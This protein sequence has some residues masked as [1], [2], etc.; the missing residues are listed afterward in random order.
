M[1]LV[2]QID[3]LKVR[4]VHFSPDN[5]VVACLLQA[6]ILLLHFSSTIETES[7]KFPTGD[8]LRQC[9]FGW[10]SGRI[11][12]LLSQNAL[13][14][15]DRK[16]RKYLNS[17]SL[18]QKSISMAIAA[19][20][21]RIVIGCSEGKLLVYSLKYNILTTIETQVQGVI[22][23]VGFYPFKKHIVAAGGQDGTVLLVDVTA[24]KVTVE[25]KGAHK[26]P[27]IGVAFAPCNKH[28]YCSI[29][30]DKQL[31]FHDIQSTEGSGILQKHDMEIPIH[32]ISINDE[33]MV[34]IGD[35]TGK[36]RI[37]DLRA[38]KIVKI[39]ETSSNPI[40][41]ICFQPPKVF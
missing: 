6:E 15:F 8:E 18:N 33:H 3:D 35:S 1:S 30:L 17:V 9:L 40:R 34:A 26:A 32:S 39:V 36:I 16:E 2:H 5:T 29:S 38:K 28:F 20:D 14:M 11:L 19:D 21:N 37:Y 4:S 12:Y 23:S 22:Q 27:V 31:L 13:Y 41:Y 24:G 25:K 7:I 10:K